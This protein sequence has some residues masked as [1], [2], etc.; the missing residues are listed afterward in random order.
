V[1]I[2]QYRGFTLCDDFAIEATSE[3][4]IDR[5]IV[6]SV[7][8]RLDA[9]SAAFLAGAPVPDDP[10]AVPR[11]DDAWKWNPVPVKTAF[12]AAL[13]ALLLRWGPVKT[14]WTAQLTSQVQRAAQ[15]DDVRAFAEMGVDATT[16][17]AVLHD[18]MVAHS[19]TA[20]RQTA[21][22]AA[23]QD[24]TVPPQTPDSLSLGDQA[25]VTAELL[26]LAL[27]LSAGNEAR[28]VHR[29]GRPAVDTA[30]DVQTHLDGLSDAVPKA[31]LGYALHVSE[32]GARLATMLYSTGVRLY[33]N[34]VRDDHLCAPCREMDGVLL[35]VTGGDM[36][37]LHLLYPNGGFIH[38]KGGINC[39][40]TVIGVWP[41]GSE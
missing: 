16:G 20:A 8:S 22:E 4:E 26:A 15:D 28:R 12:A 21:D 33:S 35:G 3:A 9:I 14:A 29:K 19:Q 31:Q 11:I 18:A 24:V 25:L 13:A 40:G 23:A 34:E 6:A 30:M 1:T 37:K 41:K 36:S 7:P 39:R 27:S 17:A 38:C 32:M 5:L 2:H 10:F